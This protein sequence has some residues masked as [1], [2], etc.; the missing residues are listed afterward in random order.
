MLTFASRTTSPRSELPSTSGGAQARSAAPLFELGNAQMRLCA[1][2]AL[3][4]VRVPF[5]DRVAL[6]RALQ[7]SEERVGR[8]PWVGAL[9]FHSENESLLMR[10]RSLHSAPIDPFRRTHQIASSVLSRC[11]ALQSREQ[12]RCAVASALG[13]LRGGEL[14]KVVLAKFSRFVL[15]QE[16]DYGRL[17][18]RLREANPEAM[19]YAL[20]LDEVGG[21]CPRVLLGASPELLV[22]RYGTRVF[23]MPLAGSRA[24]ALDPA[25]DRRQREELLA[26][27]K[28]HAE[29]SLMVGSLAE[30]LEPWVKD[31]SYSRTPIAHSTSTM[32]HLATPITGRLRQPDTTSLDLALALH[33]TAAVCGVPSERARSL[34]RELEPE[35]RGFYGGAVGM[36]DQNGDGKWFVA[37]RGAEILGRSV[38]VLSGAGIVKDSIVERECQETEDKMNTILTAL[39]AS[40]G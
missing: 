3:D 20:R 31:L 13:V 23:C 25:E 28:D 35:E 9:P 18:A 39:S 15:E 19:T 38:R 33:P 36:M 6:K 34:I 37:I 7:T 12:Y 14:K 21:A 16:P 8:G 27:S 26:S 4:T 22:S 17:I 5:A 11:E 10:P 40:L 32:W 29:H 1:N 2:E 30:A 24:R